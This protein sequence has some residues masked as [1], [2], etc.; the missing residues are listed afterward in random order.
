MASA[1]YEANGIDYTNPEEVSRKK[2]TKIQIAFFLKKM[3]VRG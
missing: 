2:K 1:L 3:K